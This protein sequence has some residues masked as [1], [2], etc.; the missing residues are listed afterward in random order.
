MRDGWYQGGDYTAAPGI[1]HPVED[2]VAEVTQ[3]TSNFTQTPIDQQ[4]PL[5]PD[6]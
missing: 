3:A 6:R 1:P 2:S 4:R 5:N